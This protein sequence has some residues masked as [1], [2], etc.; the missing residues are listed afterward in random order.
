MHTEQQAGYSCLPA[1][2]T[3]SLYHL[4]TASSINRDISFYLQ[5]KGQWWVSQQ[6]CQ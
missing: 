2:K 1:K 4:E 3:R 6:Q 5:A